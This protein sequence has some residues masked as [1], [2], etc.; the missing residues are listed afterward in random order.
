MK[1]VTVI[2]SIVMP[3][4]QDNIDTD[5]I[6]PAR[7][8]KS[9]SREG[10]GDALFHDHRF[11]PDG[12]PVSESVFNNPIYRDAK[13]LLS[14][15]NFGVG[16]SREHA[17]WALMDYGFEAIIAERFGDIFATNSL[18][19]GLLPVSLKAKEIELLFSLVKKSALTIRIQL[20]EQ[21]V[22]TGTGD[23]FHF[24]I[25]PF[26]KTCLLKGVDELG[27]LLGLNDNITSFETKHKI[28]TRT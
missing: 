8:L 13:I 19:N 1:E 25:D 6:I 14:G 3:L 28:W 16:S 27:Y 2:E 22:S 4:E 26:R 18:K 5:Q 10:F 7:Y 15:T 11:K 17:A 23:S 20:A 9:T 21:T 12:Q 24:D